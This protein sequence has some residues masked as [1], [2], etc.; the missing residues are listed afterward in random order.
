VSRRH[1]YCVR[2]SDEAARRWAPLAA[3]RGHDKTTAERGYGSAHQQLR[4]KWA[5]K[6]KRGGVPCARCGEPIVPG[7]PWDLGHDDNDRST[8]SGPEHAS[9]NRGAAG[10]K[11]MTARI[12]TPA[13]SRNPSRR[14]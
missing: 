1:T 12:S 8:Y 14:W 7:T 4:A 9:C 5:V 2:H 6:V 13:P 11:V 3:K 10:Q